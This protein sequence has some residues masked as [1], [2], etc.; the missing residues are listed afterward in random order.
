MRGALSAEAI[1][2]SDKDCFAEFTL[3]LA[4]VLAMTRF[5]DFLY[6]LMRCDLF[7]QP[8]FVKTPASSVCEIAPGALTGPEENVRL[9]HIRSF[10]GFYEEAQRMRRYA[11]RFGNGCGNETITERGRRQRFAASYRTRGNR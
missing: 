1:P 8:L 10:E 9:F 6:I 3:S 5:P 11:Y 2:F 4:N 7:S